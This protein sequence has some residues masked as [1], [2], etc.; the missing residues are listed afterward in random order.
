MQTLER[1]PKSA[2]KTHSVRIASR[3]CGPPGSG[4][5]GYTVGLLSK[6]VGPEAEITLKR[7]V[8]LDE[9][10]H[11]VRDSRDHAALVHGGAEIAVAR[12]SRL[13]V[14]VP[15]G[16]TFARAAAARVQY[17]GYRTHPF[18]KCFVCGTGRACD[19]GMCLFT[20]P[21][22]AGV[23]ASS[24]VP[25]AELVCRNGE[26]APELVCAALDCPGAWSLISAC[27]IAGPI[28]LG[29]MTY[30]LDRPIFAGDRYV[31]MGWAL[32]RERRK[33]FC[34]TAI[35]DAAGE[36]CA[37]AYSTWIEIG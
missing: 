17:L 4:N 21:V 1:P 18:P 29:R 33:S 6:H 7:P 28:V 25:S 20:G 24:W 36:V 10:M 23:V 16:I 2:P 5:G 35:Y 22:D 37:A 14:D 31:V 11:V 19:D 32:G 27:G 8:P 3:F 12:K 30:R 13:E 34:G 9:A 15:E 26:V